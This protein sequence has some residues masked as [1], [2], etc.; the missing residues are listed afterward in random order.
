MAETLNLGT[1]GNWAVKKDSLLAYNSENGNFKPLPF[2]FTRAS[3]ATVVNKDGL[4]ETVGSGEP[5]IDFSNDAKGALLLEPS[6]SNFFLF[7]E[8]FD[9]SYWSKSGG[10]SVLANQSIS[11]DGTLNAEKITFSS[12]NQTIARYFSLTSDIYTVSVYVKG[13]VGE[14]IRLANLGTESNFTLTGE[15]QRIELTRPTATS[16][17]NIVISTYGGATAREIFLW[18]A[19]LEQGSYATSYIPTQG[20]TVTR[21]ADS[22]IKNNIDTSIINSSYPF[23]MYVQS[24]YIVGNEQ[25]LSFVN[26]NVSNN[27]Y[28]ITINANVVNLDARANGFTELISSGVSLV[29]GQKFKA[30]ITM[31]SA[32][33]GKIC[34][35]GNTV[36]SK[37]N[38]S[39]Q[40]VNSNI[41][42]LLIGQLRLAT[43]TGQR[44]PVSDVK[45]YNTALTDSEL[46]ALT[47]I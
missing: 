18:G 17:G 20:S 27:Y 32:T 3:S 10:T 25:A 8:A 7:S 38:F 16:A 23:T 41:N 43:D 11:P 4:I 6:R 14:T 31:Q 39:N 47:T 34:V 15:W 19:Q 9:N 40:S 44:L 36:V 21:V 46:Q 28:V 5:R 37:T 12:S 30:A 22:C 42:D 1:D 24:T 33:S 2:D 13:N 26:S 35:N 29:N 45:V